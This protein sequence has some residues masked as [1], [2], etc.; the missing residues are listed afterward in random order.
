METGWG[1]CET[2]RSNLCRALDYMSFL[3]LYKSKYT[4]NH[5]DKMLIW[6][7]VIPY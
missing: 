3:I 5:Y 1:V 7:G 4:G 6:Q 2:A